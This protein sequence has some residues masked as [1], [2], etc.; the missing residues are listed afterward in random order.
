MRFVIIATVLTSL[1][2]CAGYPEI[3]RSSELPV[4][5]VLGLVPPPTADYAQVNINPIFETPPIS[6]SELVKQPSVSNPADLPDLWARIRAGFAL[7]DLD[8]PAVEQFAQRFARN[9][10][11]EHLAPRAR[12]YL[13]LLV[14]EAEK[15]NL[16][17]EIALLPIIESGLNPQAHSAA[18]AVGLCQFIPATGK[19]FALHQSVLG[20]RRKDLACIHGMFDY[21]ERNAA[22]FGGD[23]HLALAAYN[24]GEGSVAKS[25]EKNRRS[26]LA[27][28]YLSLRMP[29]ETR[30]YIPQLLAI[31]RLIS[32]PDRYG[33]RLPSLDNRPVIA[34]DI[35][36]KQD[37]DVDKAVRLAGISTAEFRSL[38]PG[39]RKGIIPHST[40][41]TICLPFESAVRFLTNAAAH[42]GPFASWTTHTVANRTTLAVLAKRYGTTPEVI[43][44]ANDIPAG[45]RLQAGATVLVPRTKAD[46]DIPL[47]VAMS[48]RTSIEPD[49]PDTRKITVKVNRKD[50]L[51]SIAKHHRVTLIAVKQWNPGVKD[52]LRAGQKLVLHIPVK[53]K[54][55]IHN[56]IKNAE[57]HSQRIGKPQGSPT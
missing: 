35:A 10:L 53:P 44:S 46:G 30:A 15:R 48:A 1:V 54:S 37:M 28:D 24:W 17:V 47:Q 6:M 18:D 25:I 52:P 42:K 9:G 26:G 55:A 31:K 29:D 22:M 20:D 2:G 16:P 33:I 3:R 23:W 12:R 39:I 13:Y 34:C 38:N 19:R 11:L 32:N 50:S 14:T 43:R 8:T 45:M 36:M 40:H 21:L 41:P 5:P 51:N 27:T 49:V 56:S 7:P 4:R 57:A